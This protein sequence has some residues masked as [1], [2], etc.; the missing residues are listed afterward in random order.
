MS[1]AVHD[2]LLEGVD[3]GRVDAHVRRIFTKCG[4]RGAELEAL[5]EDVTRHR[6]DLSIGRVDVVAQA[7]DE[8][9]VL[10][11]QVSDQPVDRFLK[12]EDAYPRLVFVHGHDL[13][14]GGGDTPTGARPAGPGN[15]S[16]GGEG[17]VA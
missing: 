4:F 10:P 13:S 3:W 11:V 8:A 6:G 12:R 14:S 5:C 2:P 1:A 7:G 17:G 9:D 15:S 16:A